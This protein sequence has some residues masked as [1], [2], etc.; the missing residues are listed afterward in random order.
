M[1]CLS[2]KAPARTERGAFCFQL[3]SCSRLSKY[4]DVKNSARVMSRPSHIFLMVDTVGFVFGRLNMLLMVDCVMPQIDASPLRVSPLSRHNSFIR[5]L[6]A[7]VNISTT[8]CLSL[9]II[10]KILHQYPDMLRADDV[11][12]QI[13][14][15]I[16]K[17]CKYS[18]YV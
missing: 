5:F 10:H 2:K 16:C 18:C 11:F 9:Y 15:S 4:G 17:R 3:I 12:Q 13:V 1:L 8:P 6:I 14:C 7:S